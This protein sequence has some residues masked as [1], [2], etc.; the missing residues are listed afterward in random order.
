MRHLICLTLVFFAC[1]ALPQDANPMTRKGKRALIVFKDGFAISGNVKEHADFI[2]DPSSGRSFTVHGTI[3]VDDS[4]R[5]IY[6]DPSL[7]EPKAIREEDVGKQQQLISLHRYRPTQ[8]GMVTLP[9]WSVQSVSDWDGKWERTLSVKS[10]RGEFDITQ[11]LTA[12]NPI[13]A[14]VDTLRYDW[15]PYYF[16]SELGPET[17]RS[18]LFRY[19]DKKPLKESEKRLRIIRFFFQA[20]WLEPATREITSF[21]RDFPSLAKTVAE[22]RKKAEK[23]QA[24]L[25][26][27]QILRCAQK[28]QHHLAQDGMAEFLRSKSGLV[29]REL[30]VEIQN[31]HAKYQKDNEQLKKAQAYLKELIRDTSPSERAFFQKVVDVIARELNLDTLPRLESFLVYGAQFERELKQ[32]SKH[33]QSAAEILALAATGWLQGNSVA[34]P[35]VKTARLLWTARG[36]ILDFLKSPTAEARKQILDSMN[37]DQP[38]GVDVAARLIPYLPPAEPHEKITTEL[39]KLSI[40]IDGPAQGNNYLVQLPP[41]YH[42]F[43]P[44]P[45]LMLLHSGQETADGMISRLS[46]LAA[47]NGYI[48]VAPVLGKGYEYSA[49]EH[50]LLLDCLRDLRRKFHIDSDRVFLFGWRRGATMAF[51]VALSHPDPFAGVLIMNGHPGPYCG[52][53]WP[54]A[55]YLPFYIVEGAING[56]EPKEN[57]DLFAKFLQR[58]YHSLYFEYKGRASEWYSAELPAMFQWMNCRIRKHPMKQLGVAGIGQTG[59][60]FKTMRSTDNQF[61][62]LSTSAISPR[63]LHSP[64]EAKGNRFFMPAMMQARIA[65]GNE[66]IQKGGRAEKANVWYQINISTRG[67]QQ[68][69]IW[70]GPKMVDFTKPISVHEKGTVLLHRRIISPSLHTLLEDFYHRGDRQRLYFARI[71]LKL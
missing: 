44:Y 56:S 20:G 18:L 9:G 16:T 30:A 58:H 55:Q 66:A 27:E 2:V 6:F 53:Y 12:L 26:G 21:E 69:S 33:G 22:Y 38:L 45:V 43:R 3:F 34:E 42:H 36:A 64:A 49:Q 46:G 37:R 54:N 19:P 31:L 61:Y 71:D 67:L 14:Q 4:V 57:R 52:F 41:E 25:F 59:E 1:L 50:A 65:T 60:E 35:D 39:Q 32:K 11:R 13:F 47:I 24:T 15:V 63:Y 10:G 29:D 8:T 70:L 40:D 7:V 51:D 23:L 48:L 68:L 62:W 17:V 28:G 5:Q